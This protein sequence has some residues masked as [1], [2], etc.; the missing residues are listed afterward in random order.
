M[1]N[2]AWMAILAILAVVCAFIAMVFRGV[3]DDTVALC[4]IGTSITFALLALRE[5]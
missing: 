2:Y 1:K 4:L 3:T 5:E